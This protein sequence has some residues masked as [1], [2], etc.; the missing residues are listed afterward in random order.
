MSGDVAIA[1]QYCTEA[2]DMAGRIDKV[3]IL[4]ASLLYLLGNIQK[5]AKDY[6]TAL[7]TLHAC[8]KV[9]KSFHANIES[10]HFNI[11]HV[12]RLLEDHQMALHHYKQAL[13]LL[14]RSS[15]HV[16]L[17]YL[18]RIAT[19]YLSI[20]DSNAALAR[21]LR[22]LEMGDLAC[23][24]SPSVASRMARV[25]DI[26]ESMGDTDKACLYLVDSVEMLRSIDSVDHRPIIA[27]TSDRIA[28]LSHDAGNLATA[29]EYRSIASEMRGC[30]D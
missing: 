4:T 13:R 22:A 19:T 18:T 9:R 16:K 25:A 23:L 26:Y 20:G 27:T 15:I 14:G 6:P 17:K 5:A 2:L 12:H 8:M 1:L 29:A 24:K 21:Y 3:P 30:Q 10:I 11:G 28:Q 7:Q